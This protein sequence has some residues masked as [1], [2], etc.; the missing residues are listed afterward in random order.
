MRR[1]R[2]EAKRER[3]I[4]RRPRDRHVIER[5]DGNDD[6]ETI[7][8]VVKRHILQAAAIER[9]ARQALQQ[10]IVERRIDGNHALHLRTAR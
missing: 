7:A 2:I 9:R 3:A 5:V 1:R 10:A 4:K 6:I 8:A